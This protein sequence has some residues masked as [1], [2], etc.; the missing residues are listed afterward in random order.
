MEEPDYIE[1][2][3]RRSLAGYTTDPPPAVW[4][5]I[6]RELHPE[7]ARTKTGI[8]SRF[9]TKLTPRLINTFSAVAATVILVVCTLLYFFNHDLHKV[10]GHAYAGEAR[11]CT[12]TAILFKVNDKA[13]PYDSVN[14]YQTVTIDNKGYYHFSDVD[15]GHYLLRISP[16]ENSDQFISYQTTWFNQ[17][18]P[19]DTSHL[20]SLENEDF[21]GDV[22]LLEKGD[23]TQK[24]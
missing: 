19:S 12:G 5:A 10:H 7:S 16:A 6:H 23:T 17:H 21:Y 3:F 15:D 11:L 18:G 4:D 14:P 20:I 22:F 2:T 1:E 13:A 9:W 24:K 8:N